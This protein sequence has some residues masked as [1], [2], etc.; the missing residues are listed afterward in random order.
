[1]LL[2]IH[3]WALDNPSSEFEPMG[4]LMVVSRKLSKEPELVQRL[5]A[6]NL[7]GYKILL[8][9]PQE[10]TLGG[11]LSTKS[12]NWLWETMFTNPTSASVECESI[13]PYQG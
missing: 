1:M 4:D 8:V 3:L 2:D 11:T 9:T 13:N 5:V 6:L 7:K 10:L 12:L